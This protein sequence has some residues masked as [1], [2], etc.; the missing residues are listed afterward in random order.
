M[1]ENLSAQKFSTDPS[2]VLAG[3]FIES[4]FVREWDYTQREEE[5]KLLG[6][7]KMS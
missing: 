3:Y 7:Y 2:Q 4:F 6:K 1:G 5:G